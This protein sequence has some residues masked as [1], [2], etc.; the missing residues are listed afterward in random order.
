MVRLPI[1]P[2]TR[3]SAIEKVRL[4]EDG[5]NSRDPTR[6]AQAYSDGINA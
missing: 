2:F 6:V 1:P 5:W 4:A 3:E